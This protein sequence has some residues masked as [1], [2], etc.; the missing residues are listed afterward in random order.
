MWRIIPRS[1]AILF[2]F[3]SFSLSRKQGNLAD[4]MESSPSK[5]GIDGFLNV[6]ASLNLLVG[7]SPTDHPIYPLVRSGKNW[8]FPFGWTFASRMTRCRER[9]D[10]FSRDLDSSRASS[11][12]STLEGGRGMLRVVKKKL[13]FRISWRGGTDVTIRSLPLVFRPNLRTSVKKA[14]GGGRGAMRTL[15]YASKTRFPNNFLRSHATKRILLWQ[16]FF[17]F[18]SPEFP[19]LLPFFSFSFW[20]KSEDTWIKTRIRYFGGIS[21]NRWQSFFL[22]SSLNIVF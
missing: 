9:E 5:E 20:M 13:G 21:W 1:C 12:P 8:F 17:L 6:I 2:Y 4:W 18:L 10:D 22:F 11:S 3:P 15:H 14:E 19:S 7:F 16:F